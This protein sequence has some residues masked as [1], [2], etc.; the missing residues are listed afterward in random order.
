MIIK[1]ARV[2]TEDGSFMQGDVVVK[3]GRF[4]SVLERTAD[5][6]AANDSAPQEIIDASG[7]IMIPGLVDIHFH[8]CK[9]ADMCDGTKEALDVITAYEASIGVTSVCPATMT[10]QRDELL[11][12]MKNAGDYTYHGGAHLVGINMEGP[13]ISPSKKGAQAA[14]NIMRCDYDYFC[15]S[16]AS[17][18]FSIKMT[19]ITGLPV[20]ISGD[21]SSHSFFRCSK[22]SAAS[23]ISLCATRCSSVCI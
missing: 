17:L 9:G 8:G 10:I 19:S 12:V 2:F 7:L 11:S 23:S 3:D 5:T 4:D 20:F 22:Y 16:F 18:S 1:N 13:F 21:T 14:E 15:L 6:D